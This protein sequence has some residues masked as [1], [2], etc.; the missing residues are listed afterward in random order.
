MGSLGADGQLD[1]VHCLWALCPHPCCWETEHRIAK[2]VYR[3][4]VR[5]SDP[6]HHANDEDALPSLTLVDVS[7]WTGTRSVSSSRTSLSRV[8][9]PPPRR[10]AA[11]RLRTTNPSFPVI[12][13]AAAKSNT[14]ENGTRDKGDNT[15]HISPLIGSPWGSGSLVLWVPNPH[16]IPQCLKSLKSPHCSVKEL[17]CL[18]AAQTP[19]T[20]KVNCKRTTKRVRFQLTSSPL[21]FHSSQQTS[22]SP[23]QLEAGAGDGLQVSAVIDDPEHLRDLSAFLVKNKPAVFHTVQERMVRRTSQDTPASLYKLDSKTGE[24]DVDWDSLRQQ[25]YLWKR[26][27]VRPEHVIPPG[28]TRGA[29]ETFGLSPVRKPSSDRTLPSPQCAAPA[30]CPCVNRKVCYT[31]PLLSRKKHL[32]RGTGSELD[33]TIRSTSAV[34]EHNQLHRML[35]TD[36]RRERGRGSKGTFAPPNSEFYSRGSTHQLYENFN[37]SPDTS[38]DLRIITGAMEPWGGRSSTERFCTSI[39]SLI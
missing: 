15:A 7:D 8:P 17:T 19:S 37:P 25:T 9:P 5:A 3:H 36:E 27:S 10:D 1:E 28:G 34:T 6:K 30:A 31:H 16:Y 35:D 29:E 4:A 23:G 24:E 33:M 12:T 38:R 39:P 20:S 26:H 32:S 14:R 13:S 11:P 2:G 21:T 18:P 22:V